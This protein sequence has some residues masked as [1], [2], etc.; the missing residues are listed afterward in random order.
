MR[1]LR[2]A[3]MKMLAVAAAVMAASAATVGA[4]FLM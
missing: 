3:V 4:A 2:A 1:A